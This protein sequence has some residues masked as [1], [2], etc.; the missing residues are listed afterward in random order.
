MAS[1]PNID[2]DAVMSDLATFQQQVGRIHSQLTNPRQ[3]EVLGE[4]LDRV[5]EARAE[6]QRTYQPTIQQI[7]DS[8]RRSQSQA[9]TLQ[10]QAESA[11]RELNQKAEQ[12]KQKKEKRKQRR[13]AALKAPKTPKAPA[14]PLALH[15]APQLRDEL[16]SRFQAKPAKPDGGE[17]MQRE[18]WEDW[19]WNESGP[20]DKS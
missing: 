12:Q 1:P 14:N 15:A 6:V 4:A 10:S 19:N 8:A 13:A 5:R 17:T 18:I 9:Q 16:L 11:R 3:K 20:A 2:I 7:E